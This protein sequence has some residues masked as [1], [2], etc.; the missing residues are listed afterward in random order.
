MPE[1]T[2]LVAVV[3]W[4]GL[5]GRLDSPNEFQVAIHGDLP[6]EKPGIP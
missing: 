2:L 3:I 5:S 1:K 4:A 6:R